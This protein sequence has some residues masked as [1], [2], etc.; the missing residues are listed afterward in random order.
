M[1][2]VYLSWSFQNSALPNKG[3]LISA[4]TNVPE[5]YPEAELGLPGD[6]HLPANQQQDKDINNHQGIN[7]QTRKKKI[8]QE[9]AIIKLFLSNKKYP[10]FKIYLIQLH[11][12]L[13]PSHPKQL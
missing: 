6:H 1:S 2:K 12:K 13:N 4:T 11:K 3:T 5:L 8:K 9:L 7:L 10:S